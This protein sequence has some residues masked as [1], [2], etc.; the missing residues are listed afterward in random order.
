MSNPAGR[1]SV[2]HVVATDEHHATRDLPRTVV[3]AER[4]RSIISS[5]QSPDLPFQYSVNPYR[6]C[7]H[8]CVY[9]YA[10]PSHAYMDLSPGEDFETQLFSKPDAAV[11]LKEAFLRPGYR[12]APIALGTNTDPYQ[13]VEANLRITRQLLEV[14]AA[15]NHPLTIVT[16][17]ALIQRDLDLLGPMAGRGL[18]SVMVSITSLD[19]VLKKRMEP[20]AASPGARLNTIGV[21]AQAGIPAGVFVAPVIPGLTDQEM[22]SIV[23]AAAQAGATHAM[24]SLLR[25]PGQVAELFREWLGE[26]YPL[27]ARRIMSLVMQ[28][29]GGKDNDPRFGF[30][31]T[32]T[33]PVAELIGRR[34]SSACKKAGLSYGEGRQRDCSQF[35][36]PQAASAQLTLF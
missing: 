2:T 21:L 7:E 36:V 14:F 17:S 34:F 3:R 16:K 35:R 19:P 30:R 23:D 24:Y 29:R 4:C 12:C 32:G 10:R 20:V 22:E 1:F 15:F 11:L 6:G 33:G 25:L 18:V 13:P 5:N 9:C 26:H 31:M 27:K 8:G 28:S